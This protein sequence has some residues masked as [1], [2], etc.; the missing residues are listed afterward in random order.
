MLTKL[1]RACTQVR[2]F[3]NKIIMNRTYE[4]AIKALNTLQ[5]NSSVLKEVSRSNQIHQNDRF[6]KAK[7]FCVRAKVPIDELDMLKAIHVSGTKGKG[8]VCAFCDRILREHGL[9]TGF[10][11]SPHLVEVRERIRI[12]GKLISK[13]KFAHYFWTSWDNLQ[14]ACANDMPSYFVFL[15]IMSFYIF[16][17]EKIDVAIIEVGIGGAYDTTNILRRPWVCGVTLLGRDHLTVLGGTTESIAWNKAGIFKCSVPAFTVPQDEISMKVLSQRAKELKA[18]LKVVPKMCDYPGE[19]ITKLGIE[20]QHQFQNASLAAQLC[21]TWLQRNW[22][23]NNCENRSNE[24]FSDTPTASG[25]IT[26]AETFPI[27]GTFRNALEKT[28]WPGRSHCISRENYSLY[29]DGAHTPK[30]ILASAVWFRKRA[31]EEKYLLSPRKVFRVLIF[32]CT[33]LV[34]YQLIFKKSSDL[35]DFTHSLS[36]TLK[37]CH[38]NHEIWKRL[39]G[40]KDSVLLSLNDLDKRFRTM[41]VPT[42]SVVTSVSEALNFVLGE[43]EL[44][45]RINADSSRISPR[46]DHVQVVITGS[47]HLVGAA[48]KVLGPNL[49]KIQ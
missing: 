27:S 22:E 3:T 13:E 19:M 34:L 37:R 23:E 40:E 36:S 39:T 10:Y 30:S 42:S 44:S 41:A 28:Y 46:A 32:N 33:D 12:D 25:V 31:D 16:L 20:G 8:S 4:S 9:K 35:S 15:T 24:I 6:E 49:V 18:P 26:V 21:H 7:E 29:L 17:H 5:S 1:I 47:L 43:R 14:Q 38:E 48:M 11:S 45:L 2:R